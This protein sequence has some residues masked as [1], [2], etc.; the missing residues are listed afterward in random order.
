MR[1][2]REG[3]ELVRVVQGAVQEIDGRKAALGADGRFAELPV[4]VF[5]FDGTLADTGPAVLRIAALTFEQHGYDLNEVGDLHRLI[6]PPL[7]DGFREVAGASRAE[8]ERLVATYRDLFAREVR[9]GDYPAFPGMPELVRAL[10]AQGRR[11]AVATSRLDTSVRSMLAN[12]PFPP[13]DA[14]AG[15]LEPGRNSK[16]DCIRAVL[17]ELG[18]A[19]QDAVMVGDRHHDVDGA[20]AEGLPCIGVYRDAASRDELAAAGADSLCNDAEALAALLGVDIR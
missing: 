13:F 6:G 2:T 3:T 17:A 10:R 18:I 7:H 12:L 15:R 4:V 20:H 5:D 1:R 14:I 19:P 8:A 9:P 11:V 16:A